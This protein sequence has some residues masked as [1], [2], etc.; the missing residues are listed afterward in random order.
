M[1]IRTNRLKIEFDIDAIARDFAFIKF[2]REHNGKWYGAPQLDRL[3]GD[4]YK[5]SAS[6]YQYGRYAFAMFRRPID[7]YKLLTKIRNDKLFGREKAVEVPPKANWDSEGDCICEAWLAQTLINTL[8]SS[9]S[10]FKEFH[11]CNLTG[12]L[13][14]LPLQKNGL[15]N[16][17]VA[18]KISL[19]KD[20]L[21]KVNA[22]RHRNLVSIYAELKVADG[23]RKKT[24][25]SYLKKPRFV[26]HEG[27]GALRKLLPRDG[28]ADAKETYVACGIDGKKATIPFLEFGGPTYYKRSK[29]GIIH[30]VLDSI[31]EHLSKYM[32]V[33]LSSLETTRFVE[34]KDTVLKKPK[35]IQSKLQG[36]PIR[37]A[38]RVESE[39]SDEL[40]QAL[41]NLLAPYLP[42]A[43][44]L[45]KDNRDKK[46]A[47]NLRIVHTK[48]YYEQNGEPDEYEPSSNDIQ[49]Q[50]ITVESLGTFSEAAA[51]TVVKEMIIKRDIGNRTLSLFD[52]GRLGA[53]RT[54]TFA[55]SEKSDKQAKRIVFMDIFPDGRF[56]FRE[57]DATSLA[58]NDE[59]MK[60]VEQFAISEKNGRNT[61]LVSEGLVIS[62]KDEN[63]IYRT[64]EIGLPDMYDLG[65]VIEE[66]D[67]ELPCGNRTG[68]ELATLVRRCFGGSR[69][70]KD[71]KI[72]GFLEELRKIGDSELSKTDFRKLLNACL[73]TNTAMARSLRNSMLE[74]HGIRLIFPKQKIS[75]DTLFDSSLHINYFD[76][77][78]T[79][80][81]Y[82]VGER[83][84]NVKYSFK[85]A[86]HIRKI[87]AVNGSKLIFKELLPTMDVDFVRTGQSTVV[88]F[89]FKYLREYMR[90]Q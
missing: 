33:R 15:K 85:T 38:D 45:S 82:F 21:L 81:K 70:E 53:D 72:A 67:A 40:V 41:E 51:K 32:S 52:W 4:D 26:L 75:L 36:Q 69:V 55:V 65:S 30:Q 44:L 76:V 37:I 1:S 39:E 17:F 77:T 35:Q 54:W 78:D 56:D 8:S 29:I 68:N 31:D 24:I 23:K 59:N 9:R 43:G 90:F 71:N 20:Y 87:E 80:A 10:R 73:G 49:R 28:E 84:E 14:L 57:T 7:T 79:E 13:I 18:A 34:L 89:P 60:Y 2:D 61:G 74:K 16:T 62:G 25:Q 47:M 22:Q 5:A 11:F 42:D 50:H 46:G 6:M 83:R 63:M 58:C 64:D 48:E 66:I 3:I 27:T 86:C 12:A 88:P 19:S